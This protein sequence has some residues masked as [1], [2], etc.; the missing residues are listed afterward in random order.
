MWEIAGTDLSGP[1]IGRV[2][3]GGRSASQSENF[4]GHIAEV[5]IQVR[6]PELKL[7]ISAYAF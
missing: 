1:Q 4:I 5:M 2:Y 6:H 7:K 3:M